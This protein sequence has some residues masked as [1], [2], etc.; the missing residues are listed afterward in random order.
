VKSIFLLALTLFLI[1]A[2]APDS[3]DIAEIT[4][5]FIVPQ[6]IPGLLA[7]DELASENISS[8][9]KILEQAENSKRNEQR[10]AANTEL[11]TYPSRD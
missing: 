3:N 9:R 6:D 11:K 1:S 10:L 4:S 7:A 8:V 2:P 5:N